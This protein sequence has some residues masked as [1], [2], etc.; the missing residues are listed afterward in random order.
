MEKI[1]VLGATGV[2]GHHV[3]K[4]LENDDQKKVTVYVRNPDKLD[5]NLNPSVKILVGDMQDQDKLI[6]AFKNQD[7]V[8]ASLSGDWLKHA[9]NIVTV[10][11][12]SNVKRIYW[13]SGL[14]ISNEVPGRVGMILSGYAKRYP[15]YIQAAKEIVASK[16]PYTLI[17]AANLTNGNNL[18]YHLQYPGQ[19]LHQEN[20]DRKAVAKFIVDMINDEND[21]GLNESIGITN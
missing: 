21:F 5:Q 3:V 19:K 13:V 11:K 18:E 15:E 20:V 14:G 6:T 4:F 17:R 7:V 8:V 1:L 9:K 2:I 12:K 10:L 16:T